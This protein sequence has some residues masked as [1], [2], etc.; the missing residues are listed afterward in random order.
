MMICDHCK[1]S[2]QDAGVVVKRFTTSIHSPSMRDL[3]VHLGVDYHVTVELCCDCR[4]KLAA[5]VGNAIR[6]LTGKHWS[7]LI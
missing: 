6:D 7:D 3:E 4:E 5:W 2:D 1:R